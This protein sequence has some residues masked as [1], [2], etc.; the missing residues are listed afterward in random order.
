MKVRSVKTLRVQLPRAIKPYKLSSVDT[1]AHEEERGRINIASRNYLKP[2]GRT[3]QHSPTPVHDISI[4]NKS[5]TNMMSSDTH[6]HKKNVVIKK[7]KSFTLV[8]HDTYVAKQR[9][10]S[11]S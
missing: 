4:N 11:P 1:P 8:E 10:Y 5:E 9:K 7:K 6:I 3:Q 2:V